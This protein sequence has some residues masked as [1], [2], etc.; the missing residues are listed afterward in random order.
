LTKPE[1]EQHLVELCRKWQRILRLQDWDI[2]VQVSYDLGSYQ[3]ESC[4]KL[5][6]RMAII[7]V[8][9]PDAYQERN[10]LW[11]QDMEES[12]VHELLHL[13]LAAWQADDER[14]MEWVAKEQAIEA[15]ARALVELD[16]KEVPG[17]AQ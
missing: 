8:I 14:T 17:H 3:A 2:K 12:L 15:I 7:K 4:Y 5:P 11:P 6:K 13:H 1:L 16:R 10:F 9:H